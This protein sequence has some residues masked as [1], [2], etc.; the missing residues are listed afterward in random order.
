MKY[1]SQ[2]GSPVEFRIPEGDNRPRHVCPQCQ[3]IYYQNPRIITGCL[4]IY[5]SQVLLCKRA[6]EPQKGL[7]TL[8]AGFMENGETTEAGACR[9]TQE[10][11]NAVVSPIKLYTLLNV[12]Q[13]SQVHIF[14]LASL[15]EPVFEAGI[16]SLDVQLFQLSEIPWDSLAFPTI[17]KTLELFSQE[18]QTHHDNYQNYNQ[19]SLDVLESH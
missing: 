15:N 10:E 4:P 12:P 18:Y 13:I 5:Q 9:E 6:I 19:Y 1:C 8:P 17:R 14:Y 2:C 7:W 11:A 16:E 3:A